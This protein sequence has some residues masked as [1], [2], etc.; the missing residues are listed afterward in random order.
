MGKLIC[1]LC[2]ADAVHEVRPRAI[3]Y[4][5]HKMTIDQ[6]ATYCDTCGDATLSGEDRKESRKAIAEF[7]AKV[8]DLTGPDEVRRIRKDVLHVTQKAAALALGGGPNAF[9]R[10]ERGELL[11]SG[12]TSILLKLADSSSDACEQIKAMIDERAKIA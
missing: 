7:H 3:A 4:K 2:G 10:Y 11:V 5:G 8:D 9:S 1:D 12:A 6:P